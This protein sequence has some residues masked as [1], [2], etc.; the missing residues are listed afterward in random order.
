MPLDGNDR[1]KGTLKL[2]FSYLDN[3][4]A[5][6]KQDMQELK[7]CIMVTNRFSLKVMHALAMTLCIVQGKMDGRKLEAHED[8]KN[9]FLFMQEEWAMTLMS[10]HLGVRS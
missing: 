10:K 7:N 5:G 9:L 4:R 3:E 8:N 6:I 1:F 2:K